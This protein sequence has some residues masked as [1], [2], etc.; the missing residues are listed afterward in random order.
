MGALL[1]R[2]GLQ[3]TPSQALVKAPSA[4][5]IRPDNELV[6]PEAKEMQGELTVEELE[7]YLVTVNGLMDSN[8]A[9]RK[10]RLCHDL[11]S[12]GF[13]NYPISRVNSFMANQV[14]HIAQKRVI[15]PDT[16][17]SWIHIQNYKHSIP[18]RIIEILKQMGSD[19]PFYIS[20]IVNVVSRHFADKNK[21]TSYNIKSSHQ[22]IGKHS[23][24]V[25]FLLIKHHEVAEFEES[26]VIDA[27]RGPTFRDEEAKI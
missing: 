10:E 27:W 20:D 1:Q 6:M 2:V 4:D 18:P 7:Q 23:T 15:A 14:R 13:K 26:H 25:C 12:K 9:L 8:D 17:W 21:N 5:L 11:R 16:W 19:Y 24:E 22:I 3:R